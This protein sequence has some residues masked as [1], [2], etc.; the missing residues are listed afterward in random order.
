MSRQRK[1]FTGMKERKGLRKNIREHKNLRSNIIAI[2]GVSFYIL[3][4]SVILLTLIYFANQENQ[5]LSQ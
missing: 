3:V 4:A 5:T 2:I 1:Q